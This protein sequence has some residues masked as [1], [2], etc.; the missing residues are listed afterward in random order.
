MES[1]DRSHEIDDPVTISVF[2]MHS[3]PM[4]VVR[5][6]AVVGEMGRFFFTG[7]ERMALFETGAG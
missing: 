6:M 1:S 7:T 3:V 4:G 5:E 2:R